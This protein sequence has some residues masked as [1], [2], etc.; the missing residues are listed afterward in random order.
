MTIFL[1]RSKMYILMYIFDT[2]LEQMDVAVWTWG[3]M[4]VK[5]YIYI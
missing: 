5:K 2:D 4:D 1:Q 3:Q